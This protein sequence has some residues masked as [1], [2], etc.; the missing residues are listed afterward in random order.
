M[1]AGNTPTNYKI[2]L[3][4]FKLL[5]FNILLYHLKYYVVTGT[6]LDLMKSYL[7]WFKRG[8][9]IFFNIEKLL[10]CFIKLCKCDHKN[11]K[12]LFEKYWGGGGG[13]ASPRNIKK[14]VMRGAEDIYLSY[15]HATWYNYRLCC[16]VCNEL[17]L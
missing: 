2:L 9:S 13:C 1:K 15:D 6:A 14:Y 7:R 11:K 8:F 10:F 12:K 5:T 4:A 3:I 17:L 16:P